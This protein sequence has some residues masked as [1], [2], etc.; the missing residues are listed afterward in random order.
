MKKYVLRLYK[1]KSSV[2]QLKKSILN[3]N[4]TKNG[5]Q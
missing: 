5:K 4:K 3:L 2:S 1:V